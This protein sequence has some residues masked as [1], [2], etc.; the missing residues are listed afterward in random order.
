MALEG[1]P[2]GS[3]GEAG[4]GN[5]KGESYSFTMGEMVRRPGRERQQGGG[6]GRGEGRHCE[7]G[8]Q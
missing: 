6:R 5:I 4:R 2:I 7:H 3:K 1:R 8:F